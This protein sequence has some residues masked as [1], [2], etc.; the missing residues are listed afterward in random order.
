MLS[1]LFCVFKARPSMSFF[2][3]L[4]PL[5]LY[6]TNAYLCTF[7]Y[8]NILFYLHPPPPS[9]FLLLLHIICHLQQCWFADFCHSKFL[10]SC[11]CFLCRRKR[12]K[13]Q[14][15]RMCACACVCVFVR[16]CVCVCAHA[17]E[18]AHTCMCAYM[19]AE[20]CGY[21]VVLV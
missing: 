16:V 10:N 19:C 8:L 11:M 5:G 14:R 17:Y 4:F 15:H 7:L 18:H 3:F 9:A 12:D 6:S 20:W 13:R 1:I 2:V 21:W